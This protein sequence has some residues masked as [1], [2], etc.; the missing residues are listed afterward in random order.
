[1]SETRDVAILVGNG[2]SIAFNP[3]LNLRAITDEMVRRIAA[4]S[5]DGGDV[6][7][8][9]K[10]IAEQAL[11]NGVTSDEDFEVLVGA[12]GAE[13]RALGGLERLADL[14]KPKDE[15]LKRA[16]NRVALF[17]EEVRDNGISHVL[18]VIFERSHAYQAES[19][20]LHDFIRAVASAFDGQVTFANL[21]YDTLLLSG[22]ITVCQPDLADMGHGF[23]KVTVRTAETSTR[24]PAL[25]KTESDFPI[26][27]RIRLLHL[28]G[29]VTFWS[30]AQRSVFA[31]LDRAFLESH[32]Q[33][34][35]LRASDT[36][37]RPTVVLAN[38]RDKMAHVQEFPFSLAYSLFSQSLTTADKWL[39]VGYSFRDETVNSRLRDEF[40]ERDPKP[41]VLVVTH[42]KS[43]ARKEIERALGWGKEDGDSK[44][45]L[46]INREGADG[47][48]RTADWAAFSAR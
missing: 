11:P 35:A 20:D 5:D 24:V 43:P 17:A 3:M 9:M 27:R 40:S 4:A 37:M 6:V 22:L 15:K 26:E 23:R 25:R 14:T 13:S 48:E 16:I 29:S 41:Q 46:S 1:M 10:E 30:D 18:Q 12:F 8:A 2:L 44:P 33:W 28:H 32:D 47:I 21:N 36:D 34:E 31:K 19:Q 39:I 7:R 38:Q 42:G 45:W